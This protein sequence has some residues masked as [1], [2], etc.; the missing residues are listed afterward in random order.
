MPI[1]A[2]KLWK[3]FWVWYN[4]IHFVRQIFIIKKA[5]LRCIGANEQDRTADLH[6]TNPISGLY[7]INYTPYCVLIFIYFN[8]LCLIIFILFILCNFLRFVYQFVYQKVC[9]LYA[10]YRVF[11][12]VILL[13]MLKYKHLKLNC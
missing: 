9:Q 1:S 8:I 7:T 3:M 13:K 11:L 10:F 4:I 2:N 12:K 5:P 6:L